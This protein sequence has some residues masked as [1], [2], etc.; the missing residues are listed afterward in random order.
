M[1]PEQLAERTTKYATLTV[2]LIFHGDYVDID[3]VMAYAARWID[4]GLDDQD[5]LRNWK[6]IPGT[7][8]EVTDDPEGFDR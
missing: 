5:D 7:V 1:T 6:I 4:R 8:H 2:E 3:D